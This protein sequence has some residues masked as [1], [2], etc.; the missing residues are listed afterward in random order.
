MEQTSKWFLV[1]IGAVTLLVGYAMV[2]SGET[3]GT[4]RSQYKHA[5]S[6]GDENAADMH[7]S[8]AKHNE[9]GWTQQWPFVVE[10]QPWGGKR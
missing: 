3:C 8:A 2:S 7:L 9:C 10:R 5:L 6:K 1:G 4:Y